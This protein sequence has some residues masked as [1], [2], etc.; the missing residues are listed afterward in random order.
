MP[1][2]TH[3][4]S[5]SDPS[6]TDAR[7]AALEARV[8]E[9]ERRAG[10][11]D[12]AAPPSPETARP[13]PALAPAPAPTRPTF[14]AHK[15]APRSPVKPK[16]RTSTKPAKPSR[17]P[18]SLE[19]F[20]GGKS[21][22]VLGALIVVIGVGFF[23]KL[24]VDQGWIGQIPPLWRCIA[25]ALFGAGLLGVGE[26]AGN[27]MGRFAAAGFRAAGLGVLYAT[28]YGAYALFDLVGAG[29]AFFMLV[30]VCALGIAVALRGRSVALAVLSLIG[31]YLAPIVV[32]SSH[33]P[34]WGLPAH[35]LTLLVVGSAIAVRSPR[36]RV[37]ATLTWWGTAALGTPWILTRADTDP[38]LV[39]GLV[40]VVWVVVH[41][42]RSSLPMSKRRAHV[43]ATLPGVASFS[44]TVWAVGSAVIASD[45]IDW[46]P[47]WSVTGVGL[48][49]TVMVGLLFAGGW[50]VL[51]ARPAGTRGVLGASLIAQAGALLPITLLLAIEP[52]WGELLVFLLL[53]VAAFGAGRWTRAWS[54]A[55][56]S[57]A[58][59]A[60]GTAQVLLLPGFGDP[61]YRDA[62]LW[63]GLAL[64]GWMALVVLAAGA[65]IACAVLAS[66]WMSPAHTETGAHTEP[67]P[68]FH[69]LGLRGALAVVGAVVLPIAFLHEEAE[70]VSIFAA[71]FGLALGVGL[72]AAIRR[73]AGLAGVVLGYLSLATCQWF[74]AFL[75]DGWMD[76]RAGTPV[77][78]HPGLLW[79]VGLAGAWWVLARMLRPALWLAG[80]P[81]REIR[82]S[83]WSVGGILLLIT[84][85]LEVARFVGVVTDDATARA[86]SVSLWWGLVAGGLL[87]AGFVRRIAPLRYVGIGLLLL[88]A[89][90][91]LTYDLVAL[92][93]AVRVGS[94]IGMGLVLLC[95]AA[96]YLR[97][98]AGRREDSDGDNADG[99][100]KQGVPGDPADG[101]GGSEV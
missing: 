18:V 67:L 1:D 81:V 11:G 83:A 25:A 32:A 93:P 76:G 29:G 15:P 74:I 79:S 30:G 61:L 17:P 82:A 26:I 62:N 54:L 37:L 78:A 8:A 66:G 101:A 89:C 56:Y 46:M 88:A 47:R 87:V 71:W 60:L 43:W 34:S 2:P 16:T 70:P 49:A 33:P 36:Q 59:L 65:W 19:Q 31:G 55:W 100:E 86:G 3:D 9:L 45:A 48:A 95:V 92:S 50:R 96:W 80:V 99:P 14:P 22:L 69:T 84:T 28:A 97:S 40:G 5:P 6:S 75:A 72:L 41:A 24:A 94:F 42:T 58:L 73:S 98:G 63:A 12:P 27:K 23:L 68:Y 13:E 35:L 77:F 90:K 53:G 85:T 7:I 4:P 20:I 64:S 57:V 21:L 44:T 38:W 91:V 10:F 52:R 39:L 51:K